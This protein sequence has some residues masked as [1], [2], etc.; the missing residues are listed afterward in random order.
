MHRR[1][2]LYSES[3]ITP[4]RKQT[5]LTGPDLRSKQLPAGDRNNF[6][7]FPIT[8]AERKN[9]FNRHAGSERLPSKFPESFDIDGFNVGNLLFSECLEFPRSS[10]F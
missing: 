8:S 10:A 2:G 7:G 1:Y 4:S 5:L 3:T 6:G 9:S